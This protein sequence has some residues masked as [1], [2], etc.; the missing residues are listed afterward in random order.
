MN[1]LDSFK[2]NIHSL[3]G[4]KP[5][6][7]PPELIPGWFGK[8]S[9]LILFWEVDQSI[10]MV[11]TKRS[12]NLAKHKGEVCFPGGKIEEGETHVEAALREAEEEIGIDKSRVKIIGRLDDTWS[13]A[14]YH[15]V[16]VVGWYQGKPDFRK[17]VREVE[18]ILIFDLFELQQSEYKTEEIEIR[19]AIYE[20][21]TFNTPIGTIFGLSADLLLEVLEQ[22]SGE[23]GHRGIKREREL[24]VSL[25]TGFFGR[26]EK[27]LFPG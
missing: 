11:L 3:K 6:Q 4:R 10:K 17:N 16:P 2:Q 13:G 25:E 8:A 18:E 27:K 22:G 23:P 24:R 14:A 26:K 21:S 7:F 9:V 5:Y 15:L 19:G 1:Q 20:V 12:A